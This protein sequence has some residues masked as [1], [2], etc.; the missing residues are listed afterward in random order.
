MSAVL[1]EP[2]QAAEAVLLHLLL[3]LQCLHVLRLPVFHWTHHA[4]R[5]GPVRLWWI[6]MRSKCAALLAAWLQAARPFTGDEAVA[7]SCC[8]FLVN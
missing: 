7:T 1:S 8:S 5:F 6:S 2:L 3:P 4:R